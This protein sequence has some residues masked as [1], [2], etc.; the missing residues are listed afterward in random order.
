MAEL[1]TKPTAAD[2]DDYIAA[3]ASEQQYDDC[4]ALMKLFRRVTKKPPKM[5]GPSI[6][7]YGS[8]RYT[9]ESGRS[10]EMPVAAFA[11]RGRDLVV[12]LVPGGAKQRSLRSRLGKHTMGKSCLYF[13]QLADLDIKVL[14]QLIV[15]SMKRGF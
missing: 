1:K 9:Y 11:I 14:E 15:E 3:R 8:H 4:Q 10:G 6:V 7:G 2:V 13:R 5:W 12:Y